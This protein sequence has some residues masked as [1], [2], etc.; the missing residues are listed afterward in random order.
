MKVTL[1]SCEE[2]RRSIAGA[3]FG[4]VVHRVG[5][6]LA[7]VGPEASLATAF[8]AARQHGHGR[9]VGPQHGRLQHQLFLSLVERPQQFGRRLDPIAQRTAGNVQAVAREEVFLPVQRQVIAELSDDDLSDQP[10]SGDAASNRPH[11]RRWAHH[12]IFAVPAGVLGSHVDVHFELRRD[13][14]QNLGSHPG[15]CGPWPDRSRSTACPPRSGHARAESAAAY[16]GRVLGDGDVPWLLGETVLGLAQA[17]EPLCWRVRGR[18]DDA[19]PLPRRSSRSAGR[20]SSASGRSVP[21][22]RPDVWL[23]A[24]FVR[25]GCLIEHAAQFGRSLGKPPTRAG[26]TQQVVG[27]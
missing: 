18:T 4:E 12:A 9:I 17:A 1:E 2:L 24:R 5:M 14:L 27:K 16:R 25:G 19:A 15:R 10:W 8:F 26:G 11:R 23:A 22:A 3:T 6:L 13:V 7:D 20:R 21:R